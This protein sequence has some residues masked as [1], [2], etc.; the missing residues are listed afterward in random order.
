MTKFHHLISQAKADNV[1]RLSV[2]GIVLNREGKLLLCQRSK[3]KKIAPGDWHI[4]GGGVDEG[5]TIEQAIEREFREEM[6]LNVH[7]VHSF[8]GIVH[9]YPSES[10]NHRTVFILVQAK[11]KIH[12]NEENEAYAFV[13]M[14]E[15]PDYLPA[16]VLDFN[17]AVMQYGLEQ[18]ILSEVE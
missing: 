16:H 15:L 7:G 18:H 3:K 4:P 10:G 2:A 11:G 9:D 6:G 13:S 17:R 14:E 8:S 1:S 5:E 12:L